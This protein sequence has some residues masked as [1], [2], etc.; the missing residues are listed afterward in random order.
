MLRR[1]T[2]LLALVACVF[3]AGTALADVDVTVDPAKITNGYM[4]V[5][6]LPADGGGYQFGS[7]WGFGDL[8]GYY[9]GS[10]LTLVPNSI[11]DPNEYWYK[12]TGSGTSPNCGS[13]G[14]QG[15]K[16]MEANS[17]AEVNDGSLAGQA[18]TFRGVVT[19]N[20]LTSS[21]TVIAFIKDFAPDFSS[22]VTTSV[23]LPAS[24]LFTVTQTAVNDPARHVQWG[25]QMVGPCVWVTDLA[26]FGSVTISP[27]DATPTKRTTWG[28]LK[29]L[30]R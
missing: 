23:V 8:T 24:G 19:T 30:Y 15:N 5:F 4:N 1:V 9:T 21:H 14:A 12:C 28:Q 7:G 3:S 11:G 26:Q 25:F 17:Y 16:T 2:T 20:T 6:N 18:V 22:F 29:V 13:P 27:Y 10:D